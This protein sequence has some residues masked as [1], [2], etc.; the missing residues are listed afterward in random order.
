MALWGMVYDAEDALGVGFNLV[1]IAFLCFLIA[2]HYAR[3][4]RGMRLLEDLTWES[5]RI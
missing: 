5:E 4:L 3:I 1:A 2:I